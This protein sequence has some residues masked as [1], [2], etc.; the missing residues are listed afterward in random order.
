MKKVLVEMLYPGP[1][2]TINVCLLRSPASLQD[3]ARLN[4]VV[5]KERWN[6]F[7]CRMG[8]RS[9]LQ[10]I[11]DPKQP[12]EIQVLGQQ[13]SHDTQEGK[14]KA[15][16]WG[17]ITPGISAGWEQTVWVVTWLKRTWELQACQA[18]YE[19]AACSHCKH[20]ELHSGQRQR[21]RGQ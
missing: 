20:H 13:Q 18:V 16:P 5:L 15:V 3:G 12:W 14:C 8:K 4:S 1:S 2:V 17:G 10:R 19:L 6:P 9:Y 21:Q 7:K 11:E